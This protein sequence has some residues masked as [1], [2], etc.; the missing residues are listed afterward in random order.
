MEDRLEDLAERS[1]RA[2]LCFCPSSISADSHSTSIA[3][4]SHSTSTAVCSHSTSTCGADWASTR[5][6]RRYCHRA[7]SSQLGRLY[8]HRA[9]A[10]TCGAL[11]YFRA[12]LWSVVLLLRLS[13]ERC[14]PSLPICGALSSENGK[15]SWFTEADILCGTSQIEIKNIF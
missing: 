5:M 9:V 8:T 1:R 13:V 6:R 10:S 2:T 12:H 15:L 3:V 4:D 7:V 11:S 14:P